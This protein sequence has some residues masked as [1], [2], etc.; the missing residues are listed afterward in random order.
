METILSALAIGL[1][2]LLGTAAAVAAFEH[3]RGQARL[4]LRREAARVGH[5]ASMLQATAAPPP[6]TTTPPT[7]AE[8]RAP[9]AGALNRMASPA[10][11]APSSGWIETE[12]MVLGAA[13]TADFDPTDATPTRHRNLGA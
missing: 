2:T 10:V 5:A 11:G 6:A 9:L 8:F 3:L 7:P 4:L 12:P 1:G 13:E